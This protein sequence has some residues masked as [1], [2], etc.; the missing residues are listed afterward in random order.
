MDWPD[1]ITVYRCPHCGRDVSGMTINLDEGR[2]KCSTLWHKD[3]PVARE[4][5]LV[6][7]DEESAERA[8]AE[9][10][11]RAHWQDIGCD[12]DEMATLDTLAEGERETWLERARGG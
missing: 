11:L 8:K 2:K 9:E 5:V 7:T 3:T 4:Y 1:K 12:P 6:L 10:L